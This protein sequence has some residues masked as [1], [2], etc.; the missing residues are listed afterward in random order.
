MNESC[1]KIW[2]KIYFTYGKQFSTLDSGIVAE[3]I[4]EKSPS[5]VDLGYIDISDHTLSNPVYTFTDKF[6]K[7]VIDTQ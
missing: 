7:E 6:I 5:L 3:L 4:G 1:K 2:K